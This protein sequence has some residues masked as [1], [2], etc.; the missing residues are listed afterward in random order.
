[1]S[2]LAALAQLDC[3]RCRQPQP[4]GTAR[5]AHC[6]AKLVSK[7]RP[8][9][10]ARTSRARVPWL[11]LGIGLVTA[12]VFVLGPLLQSMGWF[13]AS[14]VHEM[15]HAAAAWSCGM[16]AVPA[17]SLDGH[18]AAVHSGQLWFVAL[19]VMALGLFGLTRIL[20]GRTLWIVAALLV[21]LYGVLA[22]SG[23]RELYHLLAGHCAE[24]V[25]A[26]FCLVKALEGG[27]T[28]SRLER[29]LHSTLGWF[30][31]GR[32][33]WLTFGLATSRSARAL[34]HS[35]GSF[36]MTNDYVRVADDV[37]GWQL[38]S[39]ALA[40]LFAALLVPACAIL[41][42]RLRLRLARDGSA[43]PAC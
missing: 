40:M 12:P 35:N 20:A 21:P 24:L 27:F 29:A 10:P 32:N 41:V 15:G 30:L 9:A 19:G 1:M 39:V 36:G 5:C 8:A 26:G 14:L 11:Y 38:Q 22:F 6:G 28:H 34:Y 23:L 42:W 43:P 13:L 3:P 37:L 25:F 17:I 7:P 4:R 2:P 31:V 33:A 18:A 16:P